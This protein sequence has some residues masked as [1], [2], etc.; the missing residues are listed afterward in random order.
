MRVHFTCDEVLAM[1]P[2]FVT[3]PCAL[4]KKL[5]WNQEC[6][7]ELTAEEALE[8]LEALQ[9]VGARPGEW[10]PRPNYLEKLREVTE[11]SGPHLA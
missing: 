2:C 7:V 11:S 3:A 6:E 1:W 10:A 5:W 9:K 4:Q 8:A